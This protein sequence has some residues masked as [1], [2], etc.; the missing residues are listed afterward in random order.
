[1]KCARCG[2][3]IEPGEEKEHQ[4][5]MVCEDCLMDLLSP[6]RA[7]DPW[8]MHSAKSFEKH[9]KTEV[10]TPLQSRIMDI[11]EKT[12]GITTRDLLKKLGED[13]TVSQLE[14]EFAVLH[15]MEKV[16]GENNGEEIVWLPWKKADR[17]C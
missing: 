9:S 2:L 3:E 12:G 13:L 1:M 16:G 8:S 6:V 17:A 14:R 7:C 15:H 10:I 5:Q 4:G 11:L